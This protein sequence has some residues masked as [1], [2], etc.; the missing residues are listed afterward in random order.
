MGVKE[1]LYIDPY[2][3]TNVNRLLRIVYFGDLYEII[4][5][6]WEQIV[7]GEW[8]LLHFKIKEQG[9]YTH[10]EVVIFL[11]PSPSHQSRLKSQAQKSLVTKPILSDNFGSRDQVD[12]IDMRTTPDGAY[13]MF[14]NYQDHFTKWIVLVYSLKRKCPL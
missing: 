5:W 9:Y 7:F 12:L 10:V 14:L 13:K 8:K 1:V 11:S 2:N 4:H 6:C 3:K